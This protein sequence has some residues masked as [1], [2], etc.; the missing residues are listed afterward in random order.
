MPDLRPTRRAFVALLAG[1]AATAAASVAGCAKTGTAGAVAAAG[2]SQANA[3]TAAT[4]APTSAAA[5]TAPASAAASTPAGPATWAVKSAAAERQLAA[6]YAAMIK[7]HPALK[8][9]LLPLQAAH[10]SHAKALQAPGSAKAVV[11]P[12]AQSGALAA[13]ATAEQHASSLASAAC[14]TCPVEGAVLLGSIAAADASHVLL[15][16]S[17]GAK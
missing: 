2:S 13:L 8:P 4:T 7:A 5:T 6:S 10:S 15:L 3:T 17:L 11:L 9:T 12:G 16:H 1:G 14:V